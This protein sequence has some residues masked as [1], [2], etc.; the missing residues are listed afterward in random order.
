V[1]DVPRTAPIDEIR[2]KYKRLALK[3]HPD[4]N[5]GNEEAATE[6]FKEITAAYAVLS[7]PHER[8][9]Y[10][11]H[12]ESILRGGDGTAED[13]S[14]IIN[15]WKY[16]NS[17]CYNGFTDEEGGFYQ[18]YGK[19][20]EEIYSIECRD[21]NDL[22]PLVKFGG[23]M[24]SS[25]EVSR[26]YAHWTNFVTVLSFSW[27]D[28][29]NTTEAPNRLVKRAMEKENKKK[30][31]AARK[32]YIETV[33]ALAA[34]VKRRDTRVI[35]M[36]AERRQRQAEE[37]EQR[38]RKKKAEKERR[39]QEREMR[40]RMYEAD[41]EEANRREKELKQA[42]LLAEDNPNEATEEMYNA[43]S[44]EDYEDVD[45]KYVVLRC[46]TC[47]KDFKTVAQLEQHLTSK[48]HRKK[49]QEV[50]RKQKKG[51]KKAPRGVVEK[52]HVALSES[53]SES[54]SD[55]E[56]DLPSP[57]QIG[58]QQPSCAKVD[59]NSERVDVAAVDEDHSSES[60]DSD[61][62][63]IMSAYGK[64]SPDEDSDTDSSVDVNILSATMHRS[65][66]SSGESSDEVMT[67]EL[68]DNIF[69][70]DEMHRVVD[71][72]LNIPSQQDSIF[73]CEVITPGVMEEGTQHSPNS[74]RGHKDVSPSN[75][76]VCK[77]CGLAVSSRNKLFKHVN[78]S[79]H[80]A[81]KNPGE[82]SRADSAS[83]SNKKK[84]ARRK[85]S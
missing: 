27:E 1:F 6:A 48:A 14:P 26:F 20:F 4:K 43:E 59:E 13:D 30:R 51:I 77:V 67:Q 62:D 85:K 40:A 83:V 29:Y 68:N 72:T 45:E 71:N 19:I 5:V 22:D 31:D 41:E 60:S 23:L 17:S 50:L 37:D 58:H 7:D 21:R 47:R 8:K 35:R 39:K 61:I 36:E 82:L 69:P 38:E 42:F 28:Q 73:Q 54:A 70:N 11:D 76:F 34:F 75:E 12:R 49:E 81:L 32:K 63:L 10:D 74:K 64:R 56:G 15:L 57:V 55:S 2:S 80:A 3:Y 33:R 9:W 53:V 16:F 24:T 25:E 46:E 18:V 78:E 79:G 66:L 84:K 65:R 52:Q 44:E